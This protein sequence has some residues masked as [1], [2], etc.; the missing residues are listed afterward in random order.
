MRGTYPEFVGLMKRSG[1]DDRCHFLG[2]VEGGDIPQLYAECDLGLNIDGLNYETLLGG[3][4][5]SV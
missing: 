5:W 3:T 1:F 4:G 2:W